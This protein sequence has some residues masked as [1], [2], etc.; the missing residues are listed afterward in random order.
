LSGTTTTRQATVKIAGAFVRPHQDAALF[1]VASQISTYSDAVASRAI[2]GNTNGNWGAGSIA[3]TGGDTNAVIWWEVDLQSTLQIGRVSYFP[4]T[5]CCIDRQQDVSV[6]ILNA[7]RTEVSRTNINT[8]GFDGTDAWPQDY[9]PN[10]SGRYVR[11]ERTPV[12]TPD[13]QSG[14]PSDAYLNIAEVQVFNVF[15]P[16]MDIGVYNGQIMVAWDSDAFSTP[17]LQK[18]S[19]LSG[20]WTDVTTVTPFTGPIGATTF[21][22]LVKGP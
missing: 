5:D 8:A 11:I 16:T 2:D 14:I 12:G 10:V 20:P 1:G 13:P 6:V 22:K 3:H 4:R 9:S 17:K 7:A 19:S 15:Q 18:A 21:Y